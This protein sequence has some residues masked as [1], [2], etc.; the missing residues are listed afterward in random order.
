MR[1]TTFFGTGVFLVVLQTTILQMLPVWLG[2]PDLVLILVAFVA[3]RFDW[4]RGVFL[5]FS[6]GWMMDVVAG[7][8]PGLF[9]FEY[10]FVFGVLSVLTRNSP[11]KESA[12][13]VPLVGLGYFLVQF[14]LYT[15]LTMIDSESLPPWSWSRLI[16]ETLVVMVATIPCFV[17]FNSLYESLHQRRSMS[18]IIQRKSGNR[19]R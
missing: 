19:F 8:Y 14:L 3:Y 5:V 17:L 18:R 1:T 12:Y 11:L 7:S 4:L 16:R 10:L 6:F 2:N 13:Q 15:S 9:V